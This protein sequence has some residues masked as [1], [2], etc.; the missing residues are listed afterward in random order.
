MKRIFSLVLA[1]VFLLGTLAC[2]AQTSPA[3]VVT[4]GPA[5]ETPAPT[6]A[7][8]AA[9]T[10]EPTAEPT[11]EP[12]AA[13]TEEPGPSAS[14]LWRE[15]DTD[16]AC[17]LLSEDIST[18]NQ[19]IKD[20][21]TLPLKEEDI[22]ITLGSY[23]KSEYDRYYKDM[24]AFLE[25][26]YA[27]DREA[28]TEE[29]RYSYDA[30]LESVELD[31]ESEEFYGY[32]EPLQAYSGIQADMPLVFWLYDIK[33]EQDARLYLKLLA[34][35]PEFME[36]LVNYEKYRTELGVFMP[37]N[38]LDKVLQDIEAVLSTG[39]DSFLIQSFETAADALTDITEETRTALKEENRALFES[40]FLG[41]YQALYD[42]LDRLRPFCRPA[43]GIRELGNET[44]SRFYEYFIKY[45]CNDDVT[46][47]ETADLLNETIVRDYLAAMNAYMAGGEYYQGTL[48]IGTVEENMQYLFE[49][50][51]DKLPEVPV[52]E[53]TYYTVPEKLRDVMAPAAYLVA[54]LDD[55][56]HIVIILNGP[57]NDTVLLK[58][59]AHEGWYGHLYQYA[60]ARSMSTSLSQQLLQADA[61][62]E[63]FSQMG[64]YF[65]VKNT[66]AFDT[67][68]LQL[69]LANDWMMND[70]VAYSTVLV[71]GLGYT[72]S[73]LRSHLKETFEF[74]SGTADTIYELSVQLPFYYL[75][76]IYGLAR[77]R[78]LY[79]E[80]GYADWNA[81]YE[82]C[83]AV[84]P[85][86]FHLLEAA[87]RERNGLPAGE[88]LPAIENSTEA[89]DIFADEPAAAA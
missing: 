29:E 64:E 45:S 17:Y 73:K 11:D 41:G 37:E 65:F 13:P 28:L 1:L 23:D 85:T 80:L 72:K 51:A 10:A 55:P 42:G 66:E 67:N 86:F 56:S 40:A 84:G 24:H 58:T 43:V 49:L 87:C 36:S 6:P 44:Y 20:P 16:F 4:E 78:D 3:P 52:P 61:Y 35:V 76:Y 18:Y 57:E 34:T 71:N 9:P 63:A 8:T 38:D 5:E 89:E 33:D 26:L 46:V 19:L 27:I 60:A 30:V 7:P 81:F 68:S 32:F 77:F 50:S 74:D 22:V 88:E 79:D 54:A 21:D 48:S 2:D 75:P 12:T 53:V 14:E 59:L 39:E 15:F 47:Q 62:S 31:I 83:F 25:R 70:I 69:G 82:D